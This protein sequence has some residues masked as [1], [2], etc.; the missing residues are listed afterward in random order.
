M[1]GPVLGQQPLTV[2]RHILWRKAAD[3]P[4][5]EAG[6]PDGAQK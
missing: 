6:K 5:Q 2:K 4:E 1:L 3:A